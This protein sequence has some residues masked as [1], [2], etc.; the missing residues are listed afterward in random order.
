[1][2]MDPEIQ[3]NAFLREIWEYA[4]ALGLTQGTAKVNGIQ[5][6]EARVTFLRDQLQTRF[7]KL[8]KWAETR[9]KNASPAQARAWVNKVLFRYSLESVI[10]KR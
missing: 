3:K 10:G 8:P 9:L 5:Q 2:R 6:T 7:G 4:Y 1:M